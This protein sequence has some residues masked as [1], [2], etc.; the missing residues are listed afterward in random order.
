MIVPSTPPFVLLALATADW[1]SLA[2]SGPTTPA[3][4]AN[5]LPSAASR[6]NTRPAI[7]TTTSSSGASEKTV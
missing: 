6:P 3:S 2:A 5:R 7:E 1:I 4:W